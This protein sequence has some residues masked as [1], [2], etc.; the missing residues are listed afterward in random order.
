MPAWEKDLYEA[1]KKEKAFTVYTAHYNTAAIGELCNAYEAKYPG[2]KCNFV[3]TTTQVAYQRLQ[4]DIK[5]KNPV[6]SVFSSTDVSHYP[7]LREMGMLMKYKPHNFDRMV[8]SLKK[9]SDA[10][11]YST[12]TSAALMLISYNTQLVSE[13]DAPKSWLDLTDPKWKNKVAIGHPAFSGYVG[14]WVVL[15]RKLHGWDFFEKLEKNNPQIGRSVNDSITMLNAK[16]RAIGA[17]SEVTTLMN[18]DKG[19]PLAVVYPSDGALLMVSPSAVMT[20]APSPNA[21]KLFIEFL[22]GTEANE[23]HVKNHALSNIKGIKVGPG[24][25]PLE[26]IKVDRP[27]DAEIA[28]GIPEVKSLFRDTFGI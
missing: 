8:E 23:L 9:Y 26:Q 18:R 3:R 17:S 24:K 11:H 10:D 14:T 1:A 22:L 19:N 12:V 16:E 13:K 6:A 25:K 4:Q 7:K 28:K 21:G 20:N 27:S 5:S 2:V 15:M